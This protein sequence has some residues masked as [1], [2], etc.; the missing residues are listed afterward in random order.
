MFHLTY[1][2][3]GV[4]KLLKRHGCSC[5]V[6]SRRG[7]ER[8]EEAIAVWKREVWPIVERSRRTWARGSA[9][10]MNAVGR[11]RPPVARTRGGMA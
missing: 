8:D 1:S 2:L 10:K 6:P 4:W 7:S 3:P 11:M 9:L 5:Q